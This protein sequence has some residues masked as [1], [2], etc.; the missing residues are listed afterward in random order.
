M[1]PR[2]IKAQNRAFKVEMIDVLGF[3]L[4]AIYSAPYTT[5]QIYVYMYLFIYVYIC[6]YIYM[7][8]P[9]TIYQKAWFVGSSCLYVCVM[10]FSGLL[11]GLAWFGLV[12]C[13]ETA[14]QLPENFDLKT[15]YHEGAKAD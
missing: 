2:R 1:R 10:V 12:W 13:A 7:Y 6:I 3:G 4:Y 8:I 15:T 14:G 9:Y 11:F 5:Y